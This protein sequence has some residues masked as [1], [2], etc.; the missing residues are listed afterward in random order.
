VVVVAGATV[1][2][3]GFTGA[4]G[5]TA[6]DA[7]DASDVP[8]ALMAVA[9]NVYEVPFVK[10]PIVQ[11]PEKP[12]TVHVKAPGV[13]VTW[14]DVGEPPEPAATFTTAFPLPALAVGAIGLPGIA[15]SF[16]VVPKR[17]KVHSIRDQSVNTIRT[18][19]RVAPASGVPKAS[20]VVET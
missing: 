4:T 19:T 18:C 20:F 9:L 13:D 2:V 11:L 1:V 3:V 16:V 17:N 7:A 10:P 12:V 8:L 15:G 6:F 5:V 14:Y